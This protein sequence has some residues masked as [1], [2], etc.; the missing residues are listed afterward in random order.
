MTEAHPWMGQRLA[1]S[2]LSFPLF[3]IAQMP[4][5]FEDISNKTERSIM[6]KYKNRWKPGG[7][8]RIPAGA[9]S[10]KQKKGSVRTKNKQVRKEA[11]AA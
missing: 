11:K 2:L 6:M 7:R 4:R 1:K 3:F 10:V 8:N 5:G 9:P